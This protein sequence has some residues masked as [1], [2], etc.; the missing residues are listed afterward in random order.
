MQEEGLLQG[1]TKSRIMALLQKEN[2]S[3]RVRINNYTE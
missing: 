3:A 2:D 1:Q